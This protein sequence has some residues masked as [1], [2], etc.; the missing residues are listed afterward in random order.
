MWWQAKQHR[1]FQPA[2][3]KG[4]NCRISVPTF[5]KSNRCAIARDCGRCFSFPGSLQKI[6]TFPAETCRDKRQQHEI[7]NMKYMGLLLDGEQWLIIKYA[8]VKSVKKHIPH[9]CSSAVC[10]FLRRQKQK[11]SWCWIAEY[12]PSNWHIFIYSFFSR[13]LVNCLLI[14]LAHCYE[15]STEYIT[16]HSLSKWSLP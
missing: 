3:V 2:D 11:T 16:R 7:L 5:N 6:E 14:S 12:S 9:Q 15:H 4:R 1:W 13:G 8:F 10:F